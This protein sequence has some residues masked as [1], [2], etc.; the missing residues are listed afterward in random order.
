MEKKDVFKLGISI[1]EMQNQRTFNTGT[2]H[3]ELAIAQANSYI[4]SKYGPGFSLNFIDD[5][6]P[7]RRGRRQR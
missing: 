4:E 7:R 6:R 5:S 1:G 3:P 2:K